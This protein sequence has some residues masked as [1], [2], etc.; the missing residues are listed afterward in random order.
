M[1]KTLRP[2]RFFLPCLFLLSLLPWA[3]AM[4]LISINANHG[5][6][7][8]AARRW[9]KGGAM[10]TD[11]YD[12][13]PPW[14]ILFYVPQIAFS[15]IFSIPVY[16]MP[17]V[18]GFL[19]AGLA[20]AAVYHLLKY[21]PAF[22]FREKTAFLT[23]FTVAGTVLA[24]TFYFGDRDHLVALA[25]VP[26]LLAQAAL[27]FGYR[28]PPALLRAVLVF[29]GCVVLIKPHYGLFPAIMILH[30][31]IRRRR[32]LP[33]LKDPDFVALAGCGAGYA[34][35]HLVFFRDFI[36][37]IFPDVLTLYISTY[38]PAVIRQ[39]LG[40]VLVLALFMSAAAFLLNLG[41]RQ[42]KIV[43]T[44]FAGALLG[45]F[46]FCIQMKGFYYHLLPGFTL[47]FIGLGLLL[48][49]AMD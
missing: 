10:L 42:K 24:S 40:L 26:L 33:I 29:C 49:Y 39:S 30:R 41:P 2:P 6:W 36:F 5:W 23:S 7:L 46:F 27:T 34:I 14:V 28:I 17:A 47:F 8:M 9:L 15:E 48:L 3:Q 22:D 37:F 35:F 18:A 20:I 12:T 13:N 45:V 31:M 25:L 19:S 32:F 4:V 16:Y 38:D 43:L 21:V 1:K 11:F 44:L